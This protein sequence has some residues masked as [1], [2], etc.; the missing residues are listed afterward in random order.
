[1]L[2]VDDSEQHCDGASDHRRS[3]TASIRQSGSGIAEEGSDTGEAPL[4]LFPRLGMTSSSQ[5]LAASGQAAAN[6]ARAAVEM[7]VALIMCSQGDVTA[8]GAAGGSMGGAV[9]PHTCSSGA[10]VANST[11]VVR[12]FSDK[13]CV[14]SCGAVCVCRLLGQPKPRLPTQ[15]QLPR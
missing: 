6:E 4:G 12:P 14:S 11:A 3:E 1:M 8:A 7:A 9:V 5:D 15:Q 10:P 2:A 13:C